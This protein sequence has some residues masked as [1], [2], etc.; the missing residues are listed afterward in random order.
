MNFL[1]PFTALLALLS[2]SSNTFA[3]PPTAYQ[4]AYHACVQDFAFKENG[5][6]LLQEFKQ[7]AP[8]EQ[9]KT[10]IAILK[11]NHPDVAS[12]IDLEFFRKGILDGSYRQPH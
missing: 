8:E 10:C 12:Q 9:A 6:D 3:A 2:T 11:K 7:K 1:K 5:K 4:D